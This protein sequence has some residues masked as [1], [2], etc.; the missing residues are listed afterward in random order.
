[1]NKGLVIIGLAALLVLM[2]NSKKKKQVYEQ[3][4]GPGGNPN[5]SNPNQTGIPFINK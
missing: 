3:F 2:S 1:M 5:E 4:Y